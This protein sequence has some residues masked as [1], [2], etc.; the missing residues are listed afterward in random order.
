ME[1]FNSLAMYAHHAGQVAANDE[2]AK[3]IPYI[4]EKVV[5]PRLTGE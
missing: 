4:I 2:D 3:L 5:I 1:W